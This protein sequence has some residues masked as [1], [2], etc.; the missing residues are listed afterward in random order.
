MMM[1][2]KTAAIVAV[3]MLVLGQLAAA[4][5]GVKGAREQ[6]YE[7]REELNAA[8]A[9]KG[10]REQRYE[11]REE[12][13]AA[14]APAKGATIVQAEHRYEAKTQVQREE[15]LPAKFDKADAQ[16]EQHAQQVELKEEQQQQR[17]E[18][19]PLVAPVQQAPVLVE[20][21]EQQQQVVAAPLEAVKGQVVQAAAPLGEAEPYAFSYQVDGSSRSESGDTK[22][23]V[24]GQ[25]TLQGAD[26]S[27][28]VVDYIADHN[29]FRATVNTNEF[30]TEAKS[31]ASVALRSSQPLA[32]DLTLRAEGKTREDALYKPLVRAAPAFKGQKL[33]QEELSVADAQLDEAAPLKPLTHA[34]LKAPAKSVVQ[35]QPA[36][37]AAAELEAPRKSQQVLQA[38]GFESATAH[39]AYRPAIVQPVAVAVRPAAHHRA[40]A[41]GVV[42]GPLPVVAPAVRIHHAA[43]PV[44]QPPS[45]P[46]PVQGY[47]HRYPAAAHAHPLYA[48]QHPR[49]SFYADNGA[50]SHAE[51]AELQ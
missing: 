34:A 45:P 26:G 22:G 8:A 51:I 40:P 36:A 31:P 1:I 14:P 47:R 30:G 27:S 28:R 19:L 15:A 32:E 33:V 50:E 6:H 7:Q 13:L 25:Y 46:S 23:V 37:A 21:Y 20:Q 16:L 42:R 41:V 3:S 11:Q 9:T 29:G 38:S 48:D 39:R 18:E 49:V 24:R 17:K 35:Q 5:A 44:R 4:A 2:V 10:A 12:L 43:V